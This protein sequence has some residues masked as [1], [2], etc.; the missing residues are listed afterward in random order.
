VQFWNAEA[1]II[2]NKITGGNPISKDLVSHVYLLVFELSIQSEDLPRVFARYA[3]NLKSEDEYEVSEA[4]RLLD[5]YLHQSPSDDQKLFTME[6][7]KMHLMGMTYREIR[8]E[9]GIS[10]DTIHLA[11][12]QFKNDLSDYNITANRICESSNEL[13]SSRD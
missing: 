2:A 8:N 12:K 7:T 9:T 5:D 13:Q 4:Q 6:I 3:Y 10:L 1:Y 11:I